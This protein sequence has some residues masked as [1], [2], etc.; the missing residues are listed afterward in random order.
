MEAFDITIVGGGM[1]GLTMAQLVAS[2]L[3]E[4]RLC[5]IEQHSLGQVSEDYRESFDARNTALSRGSVALLHAMGLWQDIRE[6]ATAILS[7]HVS[8]R[9]HFGQSQYV[10]N[11]SSELGYVVENAW[12]GRCLMNTIDRHP[13]L[14]IIAPCKVEKL[15]VLK[16]GVN[17]SLSNQK[18]IFT[19]LLV[20]ADGINSSMRNMLGIHTTSKDYHQHAVVA[21]LECELPHGGQAF[22]RFTGEGPIA[23]LPLGY[24][25]EARKCGLIFTRPAGKLDETL[26]LS[27]EEFLEKIQSVF[28]YRL[29]KFTKVGA[30]SSYPLQLSFAK[31]QVRS[32]IV[33]VGNA[34]HFLHP[35][36]GQG[37]NLALRDVTQLLEVMVDQ[38]G[39]IV[40]GEAS[41]YGE[42]QA[43]LRYMEKQD[44]DQSLTTLVSDGF[45]TL[46]ANNNKF[47]QM[48]RNVGL[49]AL[50]LND[51]LK[52]EI[53][54]RMMGEN[55]RQ[56]R[57]RLF[58]NSTHLF[59]SN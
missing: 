21:N 1:V 25:E 34:A 35:V 37:F 57:L 55:T 22:E 47:K 56:A 29:G 43:L 23:L 41:R 8:D 36:A 48:A 14:H 24:S 31:E 53:F 33:L 20:V 2:E 26:K 19:D 5:L 42:L 9:G 17:L 18:S 7:V 50:E 28:G 13:N 44:R 45:N 39:R 58:N 54:H 12:L 27:D 11:P 59:H 40:R 38:Q 10:E 16:N 52:R 6:R 49:L 32:S 4:A 51:G 30:R 46:F 3:P 15:E